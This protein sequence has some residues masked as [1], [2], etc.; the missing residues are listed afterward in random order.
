MSPII[1]STNNISLSSVTAMVTTDILNEVE[2]KIHRVKSLK[3][4]RSH[5]IDLN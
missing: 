2:D 4:I 5:I 1:L 3:I